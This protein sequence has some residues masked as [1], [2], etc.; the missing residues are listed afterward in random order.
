MWS[1]WKRILGLGQV[2]LL[3]YLAA[4]LLCDES[5][6]H[7]RPRIFSLIPGSVLKAIHG[8]RCHLPGQ[9]L[10]WQDASGGQTMAMRHVSDPESML[11]QIWAGKLPHDSTPVNR[12]SEDK[13]E[14]ISSRVSGST[15]FA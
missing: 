4:N 5:P 2:R 14:D 11:I 13:A 3:G 8:L 15:S 7:T 9:K 6:A 10:V 12:S 1:R